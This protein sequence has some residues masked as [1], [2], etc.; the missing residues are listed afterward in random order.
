MTKWGSLA[1]GNFELLTF[2][3]EVS[4]RFTFRVEFS[5]TRRTILW[6]TFGY[7]TLIMLASLFDFGEG[8]DPGLSNEITNA[9][10]Y[11]AFFIATAIFT[12]FLATTRPP[13]LA[14]VI[15]LISSVVLAALIEEIQPYFGRSRS[16]EDLIHGASG[17]AAAAVAM[18]L[19]YNRK[20]FRYWRSLLALHGL[21]SFLL[22]VTR[23]LPLYFEFR[24][25]QIRTM[26]FPIL[27]DFTYES[28]LRLWRT[29]FEDDYGNRA[30]VVTRGY[31]PD[32]HNGVLVGTLADRYSGVSYAAGDHD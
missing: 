16:M 4:L 31:T 14:T 30:S 10:H 11:P 23:A 24:A 15:S 21:F 8:I 3:F 20:D 2:R 5:V 28:E 7:F 22:G 32:G 27:S 6:L 26:R 19:W 9:G 13:L 25:I 17:S 12:L 29:N 1:P 18:W